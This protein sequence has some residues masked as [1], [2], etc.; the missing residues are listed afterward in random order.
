MIG[1]GTERKEDSLESS[2]SRCELTLHVWTDAS[3]RKTAL[4]ILDRIYGLLHQGTISPSGL[5]LIVMR[6][7]ES[8]TELAE[9]GSHMH[10]QITF[11][12]VVR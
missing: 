7:Q 12:I 9:A 4:T 1:D 5:E 6:C 2:T 10:G 3:E 11:E 8:L